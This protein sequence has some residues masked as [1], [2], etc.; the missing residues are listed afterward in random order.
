MRIIH[1]ADLHLDS[2]LES[3]L[4]SDAAKIRRGELLD[5]FSNMVEYAAAGN[6]SVILIAGDLFDKVHI[7]KGAKRRVLDE[8]I[9]HPDI[10]F[11]YLLGNH[12]RTDFLSDVEEGD[13][14]SNLK[15]FSKDKW[16]SY[17][18]GRVVISGREL[19]DDNFKTISVNLILDES[20]I[21]IVTLHGQESDYSG[22]DRTHIIQ[23]PLFRNKYIDYL[24]L[25]HIHS[26]KC[27]RLD[28]RGIYCYPGCLEGRG[29]DECGEKGFVLLDIDEETGEVDHKFVPF[30]K[31]KLNEI[32]ITVQEDMNMP[33]II[34]SIREN[35]KSVDGGDLLKV[36]LNGY[37]EMD[38]DVDCDRIANIFKR[39]FYFFKVYDRT[40]TRIDYESF[41][42][43]RSLK[44]EFV[45]LMQQ[46]DM[47]EDERAMIIETGMKA[48]LGEEVD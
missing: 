24:A 35:T 38:F 13:V 40:N 46:E 43:D 29:F 21:N 25:G 22:S 27:G 6:V 47:S 7:R 42:E 28:D 31:R 3:N 20:K 19:S 10:D 15:L 14:P 44:G 17:E 12:D 32:S 18:Y 11:L 34:D 37:T 2:K 23:L 30:A 39:E 9:T 5:T 1:T 4:D 33:D 16:I 26:Y 8:I 36:I 48:I 45:R 41:A